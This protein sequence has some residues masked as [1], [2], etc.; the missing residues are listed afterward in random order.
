MSDASVI[1]QRKRDHLEIVAAGRHL[2]D[3]VGL[4]FDSIRFEH[5]ALPEMDLAEVELGVAFLGKRLAA[6]IL[7]SSMTGGPVEADRINRHL[8]EAAQAL[9]IALGVGSQRIAIE[10]AGAAGIGTRLREL[11]PDVPLLANFGGAQIALG[12]GLDEA[13]RVV[14][15]IG[16]DALIVHLNP[17]Q[18]VLQPEGDRD[19]RG[20]LDGIARIVPLLGV[21]LVVKEVGCGLSAT[22]A[23]QLVEAGVQVLDVAGSGGTSWAA[24]EAERGVHPRQRRVAQPFADWGISTVD[25]LLAVREACPQAVIIGSGGVRHGLD[26][27]RAIRLGA[28]LVGQAAGALAAARESTEAVIEH[29]QI[30]IDQLR[31]ACFCTGSRDLASL[32]KARLQ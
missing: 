1:Q 6:P 8:A 29:F 5:C 7:I 14:E 31:I 12:Y 11:A 17:L 13:R 4:G 27:A 21:P 9:G 2:T 26:A 15:M 30:L 10:Q 23:R 22:V 18:E 20:V 19:W 16:A 28:D 32:R 24:I 25:S 3:Q